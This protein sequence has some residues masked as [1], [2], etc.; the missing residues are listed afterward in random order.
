MAGSWHD[1]IYG[2]FDPAGTVT[3]DKLPG[4]FWI[5]ALSV[6]AFGYHPASGLRSRGGDH[7]DG[8]VEVQ[9]SLS[10]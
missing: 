9:P 10:C 6:R 2:S 4:P 3:L 5:Q 7:L 8:A 1:F